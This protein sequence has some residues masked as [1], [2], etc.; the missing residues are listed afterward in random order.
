MMRNVGITT[1]QNAS[2]ELVLKA[3]G[4]STEWGVPYVSRSQFSI[5]ALQE[6]TGVDTWIVLEQNGKIALVYR[7]HRYAFSLNMAELRIKQWDLYRKD[8]LAKILIDHQINTYLDCTFGNGSDSI[9]ASYALGKGTKVVGVEASLVLYLLGKIGIRFYMHPK[10]MAI[11]KAVK[12]M[13]V[14]HSDAYTYLKEQ[15]DASF[16]GIYFDFMF[17]H[18]VVRS[19]NIDRLRSF[20]METRMED[21]LWEEAKRVTKGIIIMKDRPFGD[22]FK[23]KKPD[24]LIGGKYSK[25][26]YGIWKIR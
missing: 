1:S 11:T 14:V 10:S 21:L 23:R 20:G 15:E 4:L 8:Y 9:M 7:N 22:W 6:Q 24:S 16:D 12:R 3:K 2:E 19:T 26:R 13:E 18:S 5:N 25:V 17:A